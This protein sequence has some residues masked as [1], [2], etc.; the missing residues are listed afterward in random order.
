MNLIDKEKQKRKKVLFD[1]LLSYNSI[2]TFNEIA[3]DFLVLTEQEANEL[4]KERILSSAWA[5]NIEFLFQYFSIED[6]PM[7]RKCISNMIENFCELSND[8]ILALIEDKEK[9]ISD[10]LRAD[11]RG[12]F[13]AT[14]D[15]IEISHKNY[16]IYKI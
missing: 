10:A 13:I 2:K 14:Y 11:G 5:F 15:G 16:L 7:N 4:A 6:S 12:F 9:F 1:Y 8:I 3:N